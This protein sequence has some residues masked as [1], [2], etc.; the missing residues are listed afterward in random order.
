MMFDEYVFLVM[1]T[2]HD[3]ATDKALQKAVQKHMKCAGTLFV[4]SKLVHTFLSK[5]IFSQIIFFL[6][7]KPKV[8]NILSRDWFIYI[9][10]FWRGD[11]NPSKGSS[12]FFQTSGVPKRSK[13][14]NRRG[15][16]WQQW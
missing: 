8:L 13:K 14:E 10:Y 12:A 2:Q 3:Q 16:L 9:G 6:T 11:K 15:L 5:L 4:Q 1:E 7:Q